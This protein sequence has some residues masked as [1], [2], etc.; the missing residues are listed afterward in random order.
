MQ[1][2]QRIMQN[3]P[4]VF[5]D[6]TWKPVWGCQGLNLQPFTCKACPLPMSHSPSPVLSCCELGCGGVLIFPSSLHGGCYYSLLAQ[7]LSLNTSSKYH[8]SSSNR[9]GTILRLRLLMCLIQ[10]VVFIFFLNRCLGKSW[11][12]EM[13]TW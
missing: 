7:N 2:E 10:Y 3:Q 8:N 5:P 11:G 9:C 6:P 1:L 4:G 12:I 13:H